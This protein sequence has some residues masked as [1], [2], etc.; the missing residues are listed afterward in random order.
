MLH[1]TSGKKELDAESTK[2]LFMLKKKRRING[3]ITLAKWACAHFA[4]AESIKEYI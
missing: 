3:Q 4:C 2:A 1:T